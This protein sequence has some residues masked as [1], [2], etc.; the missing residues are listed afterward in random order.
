M[1]VAV[2][3]D[4][5]YGSRADATQTA[6]YVVRAA[7]RIAHDIAGHPGCQ[8]TSPPQTL[9]EALALVSL[10]VGASVDASET[11]RRWT[12]P[13]AGGRRTVTLDRA[14]RTSRGAAERSSGSSG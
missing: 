6:L 11:P 4:P 12:Q 13:I 3:A 5:P 10:L 7:D 1:T 8:Y 14:D 2:V 9:A